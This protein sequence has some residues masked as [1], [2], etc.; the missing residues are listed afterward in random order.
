MMRHCCSL[1][2]SMVIIGFLSACPSKN[3]SPESS[4]RVMNA[5]NPVIG[6]DGSDNILAV[7]STMTASSAPNYTDTYACRYSQNQWETPV[8]IGDTNW[9]QIIYLQLAV[10]A[11]GSATAVWY[12]PSGI[13][14]NRYVPGVG[15]G[16]AG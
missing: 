13:Y 7:W 16:S 5:R 6:I 12:K 2:L 11:K 14:F 9:G 3:S 15:W 10:S 8:F 4:L 1:L